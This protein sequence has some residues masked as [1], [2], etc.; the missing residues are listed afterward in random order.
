MLRLSL[1]HGVDTATR[2]AFID[3]RGGFVTVCF[4]RQLTQ[5]QNQ[6]GVARTLTRAATLFRHAN[7]GSLA[8]NSE[9]LLG[10]RFDMS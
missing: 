8:L 7:A 5:A 6:D 9:E 3:S 4:C 1:R 2:L 10:C